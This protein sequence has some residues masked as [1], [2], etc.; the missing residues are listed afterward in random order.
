M[1]I[2]IGTASP[3]RVGTLVRLKAG[4]KGKRPGK[5]ARIAGMVE[6]EPGR[7][8]VPYC[9]VL[10][11]LDNGTRATPEDVEV[12]VPKGRRPRRREEE[13]EEAK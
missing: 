10:L 9:N 12:I 3:L 11:I 13:E 4:V 2:K 1:D 7:G 8:W 5:P 6:D